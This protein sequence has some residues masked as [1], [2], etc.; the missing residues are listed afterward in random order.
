[1]DRFKKVQKGFTL[2]ELLIVIVILGILATAV[3]VAMDPAEQI[4]RGKDAGIISSVGQLGHAVQ[5]Y[6]TSQSKALPVGVG[7]GWNDISVGGTGLVGSGELKSFPT[8][9]GGTPACTNNQMGVPAAG[10]GG[11]CYYVLGA[12]VDSV[13]YA[14][15]SSKSSI[16]KVTNS[17]GSCSAV[18]LPWAVFY[19]TLGKA[20]L[21]C[22]TEAQVIGGGLALY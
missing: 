16:T 14:R 22:G 3:L 2:I 9:P 8:A 6:Y 19:T 10:P 17:G 20:G 13:V 12:S 4:A 15:V 7:T 5:A 21:T 18:N 11:F 1:M